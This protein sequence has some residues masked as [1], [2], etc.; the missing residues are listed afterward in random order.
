MAFFP[1]GKRIVSGSEDETVRIWDVETGDAL[2]VLDAGPGYVNSVGVTPD[3]GEIVAAT[4][5]G[6]HIWYSD[7]ERAREAWRAEFD[8]R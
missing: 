4:S 7:L 2:L 6:L 3:G 5:K 1:D 8:Q